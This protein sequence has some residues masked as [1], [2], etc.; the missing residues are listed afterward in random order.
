MTPGAI[1]WTVSMTIISAAC[2]RGLAIRERAVRLEAGARRAVDFLACGRFCVDFRAVVFA[3]A[4][5]FLPAFD[6]DDDLL[7]AGD[8][9]AAAPLAFRAVVLRPRDAGDFA[10]AL[11]A[12]FFFA[13][14]ADFF[15]AL[16]DSFVL[17]PRFAVALEE[18]FFVAATIPP[19]F[20][21]GLATLILFSQP[22]NWSTPILSVI[23]AGPHI[24]LLATL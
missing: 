3:R 1:S 11:V 12:G 17:E 18:R 23:R 9:R 10:R 7:R 8:L 21:F 13:V 6:V 24:D 5:G 20:K 19:F 2:P 22:W 4:E 16:A 14:P 15:P